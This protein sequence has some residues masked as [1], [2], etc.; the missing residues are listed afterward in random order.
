MK[1]PSKPPV[2]AAWLLEHLLPGNKNDPLVGDLLEAFKHRRSKAWFWRQVLIAIMVGFSKEL[3]SRWAAVG[4]SDVWTVAVSVS[5]VHLKPSSSYQALLGWGVGHVWPQ[6]LVYVIAIYLATEL[7]FVW[8]GLSVY[9]VIMKSFNLRS[10]A[11]GLFAGLLVVV[12]QQACGIFLSGRN[13]PG[14]LWVLPLFFAILLSMWAARSNEED[15]RIKR[16]GELPV[17]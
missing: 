6:S 11:R 7:G 4:C 2:I 9:L 16:S 13:L 1:T 5:W 3:R 15:R 10:H 17:E 8:V 14:G 12:I